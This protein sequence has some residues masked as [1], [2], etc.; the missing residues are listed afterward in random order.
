V[1]EVVA[2]VGVEAVAVEGMVDLL[3][4]QLRITM[5]KIGET[6]LLRRRSQPP[7]PLKIQQY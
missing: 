6:A 3:Q 4:L 5:R 1:V 7:L 2:V